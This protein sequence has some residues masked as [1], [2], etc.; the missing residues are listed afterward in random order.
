MSGAP[1]E[2]L[3]LPTYLY[4]FGLPRYVS[5]PVWLAVVFV[6]VALALRAGGRKGLARLGLATVIASP[7]L[8]AHGFL[9]AIP[10]FLG[11]RSVWLWAALGIT[12][13][14][15]DLGWWAAVAAILASWYVPTLRRHPLTEKDGLHPLGAVA[16]PWPDR[17]PGV[18]REPKP[19]PVAERDAPAAP[20]SAPAAQQQAGPV[21]AE[22][23]PGRHE[24]S[25][26]TASV[27]EG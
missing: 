26:G 14:A 10:A 19:R 11:L 12:S 9:V 24:R 17:A 22:E 1:P 18:D 2:E 4:G 13:V 16:E 8:F 21:P 15:P 27:P 25:P 20:A 6:V 3:A 7:S 23:L 5:E